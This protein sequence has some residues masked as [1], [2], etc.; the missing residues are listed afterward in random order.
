MGKSVLPAY[1]IL[2]FL[3][4]VLPLAAFFAIV[5]PFDRFPGSREL[6]LAVATLDYPV[7]VANRILP[8]AARTHLTLHLQCDHTYCFPDSLA[9]EATRFMRVGTPAYLL[10]FF[11]PVA[12]RR[13]VKNARQ[14]GQSSNTL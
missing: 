3:A 9:V 12:V 14:R 10:L 11:A 13:W 6:Q 7:A 5:I 4:I 1:A 2:A 8:D